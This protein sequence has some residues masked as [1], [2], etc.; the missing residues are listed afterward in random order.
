MIWLL[1]FYIENAGNYPVYCLSG[2]KNITTTHLSTSLPF[3]F[4]AVVYLP[5]WTKRTTKVRTAS[6]IFKYTE[7]YDKLLE[8]SQKVCSKEL[9][10]H[11]TYCPCM[12]SQVEFPG[13]LDIHI[14]SA[15]QVSKRGG[16]LGA[17]QPLRHEEG[18]NLAESIQ[19]GAGARVVVV[20]PAASG[21]C[22]PAI[23]LMIMQHGSPE[24]RAHTTFSALSA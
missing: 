10:S 11:R 21:C 1:T 7:S 15:Q 4:R 3:S 2:S 9:Y 23:S 22:V 24:G 16:W 14:S 13:S 17:S 8:V 20:V 12:Y 6:V 19:P 5:A 18:L